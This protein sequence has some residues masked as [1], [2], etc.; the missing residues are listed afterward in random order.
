M[1]TPGDLI[2]FL[3]YLKSAFRP[4]QNMSKYTGRIAKAAASAERILEIMDTTP[5]I[6]DRP[7][8]IPA[9]LLGTGK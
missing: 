7:D 9:P 2:V 4:L 1:L 5:L 3:A 6:Q 8:A